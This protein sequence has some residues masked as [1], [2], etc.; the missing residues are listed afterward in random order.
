MSNPISFGIVLGTIDH[1]PI[2]FATRSMYATHALSVLG[3]MGAGVPA[4]IDETELPLHPKTPSGMPPI[5][6]NR[7][8]ACMTTPLDIS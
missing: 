6:W 1:R 4:T 5:A 8:A 3:N 7:A 2:V